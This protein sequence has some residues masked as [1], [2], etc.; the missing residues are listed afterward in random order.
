MYTLFTM[1]TVRVANE[2]PLTTAMPRP[3]RFPHYQLVRQQS[4]MHPRARVLATR[5]TIYFELFKRLG[6]QH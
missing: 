4:M 1:R 6:C 5:H 2:F 3:N